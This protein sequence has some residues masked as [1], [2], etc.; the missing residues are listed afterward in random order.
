MNSKNSVHFSI[1]MSLLT[2]SELRSLYAKVSSIRPRLIGLDVGTVNVGVALSDPT[3]SFA[4]PQ[5]TLKRN[6]CRVLG[7]P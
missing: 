3:L 4:T 6:D 5:C 1:G 7:F 2:I